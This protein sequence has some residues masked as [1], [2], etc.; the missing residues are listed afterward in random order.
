MSDL[1]SRQTSNANDFVT[2][3][4]AGSYGNGRARHIQSLCE[5][6]DAGL[7]GASLDGRR[8]E[9]QLQS[10]TDLP[11]DAVLFGTW[12]D[13]DG[14]RRAGWRVVDGNHENIHCGGVEARRIPRRVFSA[15]SAYS[16]SI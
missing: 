15:I 7:I 10:I 8:G 11:G 3:A 6:I 1:V 5:E 16:A 14:K 9:S 12:V 4:L 2:A 13:F